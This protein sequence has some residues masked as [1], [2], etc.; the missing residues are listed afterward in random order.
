[1]GPTF[2]GGILNDRHGDGHQL[3]RQRNFA[4]S[5]GASTLPAR[6]QSPPPPSAA[7]RPSPGTPSR[8][9]GIYNDNEGSLTITNS[10]ISGNSTDRN[11]EWYSC[12]GC[13][14]GI[15]NA[16][17][18][19]IAASTISGNWATIGG[20]I[21]NGGMTTLLT[22]I[23]AKNSEATERVDSFRSA[24]TSSAIRTVA[25]AGC[26]A[27][28]STSTRGSGHCRTTAGLPCDDG[29]AAR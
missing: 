9:G 15:Y 20:G 22:S 29:P 11:C 1:M 8:G 12:G 16:G 5:V 26:R 3:H 6:R 4:G 24:T 7:T 10:T 18:S 28:C 2:G 14:G 21:D 19:T 27:T 23:V 17:T 25:P 13:G